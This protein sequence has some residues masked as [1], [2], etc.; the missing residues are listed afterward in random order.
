MTDIKEVAAKIAEEVANN[1]GSVPQLTFPHI[2]LGLKEFAA[3]LAAHEA[4]PQQEPVAWVD[5]RAIGWLKGRGKSASITTPLQAHKSVE[6]PM[7]LYAAPQQAQDK[8]DAERWR[9]MLMRVGATRTEWVGGGHMFMVNIKPPSNVM[10]GS[11][12]QHFTA[13]IDAA[14]KAKS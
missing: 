13:A 1:C 14:R 10:Q 2:Y 9:E 11:V 12:A 8:L 6:R 7:P 4:A 5:E 3:S